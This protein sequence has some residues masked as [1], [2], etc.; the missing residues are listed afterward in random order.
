MQAQEQHTTSISVG[1]SHT[2]E[3]AGEQPIVL[4]VDV[5]GTALFRIFNVG[6]DSVLTISDEAG[7][8]I[9]RAGG[10][11]GPEHYYYAIVE[12][13]SPV[14]LS[15]AP[16][17]PVSPAGQIRV[18]VDLDPDDNRLTAAERSMTHG[19]DLNLAYYYGESNMR[20]E[21]L[22]SYRTHEARLR[23]GFVG[24]VPVVSIS[25]WGSGG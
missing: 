19:A 16:D 10:W 2:F 21:A 13:D 23:L 24:V 8:R 20:L 7:N 12:L 3:F 9:V 15:I 22:D 11:R 25:P 1:E 4:S 17:D 14:L 5:R 18:R 6:R